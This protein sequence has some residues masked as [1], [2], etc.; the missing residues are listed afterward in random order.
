MEFH[1]RLKELR[2]KTGESQGEVASAV[3]CAARQYQRFEKSEQKP[4]FDNLW[5]LADHFQV[6][7][8]FL[9][10]RVDRAELVL[11]E[12]DQTPLHGPDTPAEALEDRLKRLRK[13]ARETQPVLAAAIGVSTAQILRFEK[14]EQKPG[15]DNLWKLADHF[16]VTMDYLA[17]RTDE[18]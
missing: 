9:M 18:P 6:S 14:G 13:L 11:E 1:I 16:G 4:G 8:D 2:L 17:G 5:K 10:G 12:P 3:G 7:V 15:L